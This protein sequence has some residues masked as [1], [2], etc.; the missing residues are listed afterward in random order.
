MLQW[1]KHGNIN[2][3]AETRT[4]MMDAQVIIIENKQERLH[5]MVQA[6]KVLGYHNQGHNDA[7]ES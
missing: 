7:W 3:D 4:E 6:M 2:M 5:N 1:V